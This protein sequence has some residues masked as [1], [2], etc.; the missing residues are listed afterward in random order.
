MPA[1]TQPQ[2]LAAGSAVGSVTAPFNISPVGQQ[3]SGIF[4]T[5]PGDLGMPNPQ[6][7]LASVLPGL[8]G[9]T[10]T[11]SAD[12][13]SN[14]SGILSPGTNTSLQNAAANFGVTSGMPGSGLDW[15][16]LYGNIA[17]ASTSQQAL[18]EQ[19]YNSLI[20]TVSGTQTVNPQLQ[21]Q[22]AEQNAVNNAAP[23]PTDAGE[24]ALGMQ[25]LGDVTGECGGGHGGSGASP[26]SAGSA[27]DIST[28]AAGDIG[29]NIGGA[30]GG[31]GG[32]GIP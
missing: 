30:M 1:S 5:V 24:M 13:L 3:G 29:S 9:L 18:G 28:G 6:A 20:P 4:G 10:G 14:L 21:T 15:N 22:I 23:N 7:D 17:G 32:M 2:R 19:Q 26:V 27:G 25:A 16:S 8:S 31:I 11:A 12:I